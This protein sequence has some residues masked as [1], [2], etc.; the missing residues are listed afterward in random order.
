MSN[1]QLAAH[2]LDLLA[3]L[4]PG[5]VVRRMFSGLGFYAGGLFFA[6][7]DPDEGRLFFKV[8]GL[9]RARFLE[10]GGR[11]FVYGTR[12]GTPKTMEGY[13][14]P[15]D[16]AM[17]DPEAMVPWARLALEAS[18]R[19]AAVKAAKAAKAKAKTGKP[20]AKQAKATPPAKARSK[21]KPKPL[22]SRRSL[23]AA[24]R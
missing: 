19:A 17:E 18:G 12:R 22:A 16:E 24:R 3:P 20:S 14:S 21:P 15:P 11:P 8:D 4:G 23:R 7:G 2:A 13:C 5:V 9:T 10:A 6:I 1:D